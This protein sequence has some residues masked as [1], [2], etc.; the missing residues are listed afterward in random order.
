[1]EF[2]LAGDTFAQKMYCLE[3]LEVYVLAQQFGEKVWAIVEQWESFPKW[4]IG[5][6]L[7]EAADSI[8]SNIAE[9]YGRYFFKQQV[10]FCFYARGSLMECRSWLLK[11]KCR[12]LIDT[13]KYEELIADLKIIHRKL[14]GYIKKLKRSADKK[15]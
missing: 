8:G 1:M 13:E 9:G 12:Q 5:S 11:A 4:R 2:S 3:E 15:T 14:N 7:T 10:V 6:Q